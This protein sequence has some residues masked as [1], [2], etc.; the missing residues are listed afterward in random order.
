[1]YSFKGQCHKIFDFR[2]FH[3][4][5]SPGR[6]IISWA[7]FQTFRKIQEDIQDKVLHQTP[8]AENWPQV[9][10]T[11]ERNLPTG[12]D[13]NCGHIFSQI[14]IDT[15]GNFSIVVNDFGYKFAAVPV[16]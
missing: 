4:S 6:L 11:L 14:F 8:L 1:M 13:D 16:T 7:P 10:L 3:Q 2:F 12:G 9:S 15:G 5:S